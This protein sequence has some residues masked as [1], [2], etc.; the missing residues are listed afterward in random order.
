MHWKFD[1]DFN[2]V[3]REVED[4]EFLEQRKLLTESLKTQAEK[5]PNDDGHWL[6]ACVV[7]FAECISLCE[8]IE[9]VDA[10]LEEFYD[11]ADSESIWLGI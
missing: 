1:L 9:E 6:R 4:L 10:V 8:D 3:V 2:R 11:F 5:L 7:D